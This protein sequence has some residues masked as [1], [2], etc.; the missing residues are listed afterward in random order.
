MKKLALKLFLKVVKL[1]GI[2]QAM[3]W[4]WKLLYPKLLKKAESSDPEWDEKALKLV[5]QYIY[6]IIDLIG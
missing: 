6:K 1:V 3:K 5:N 2:K 4:G